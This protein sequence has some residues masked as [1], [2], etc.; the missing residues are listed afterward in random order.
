MAAAN[1]C[2][3][4]CLIF[5][6]NSSDSAKIL[7]VF[8]TAAP[9][10]YILGNALLR[11]L[12]EAGH[13]V[14]MIK[15]IKKIDPFM[16]EYKSPMLSVVMGSLFSTAYTEK[17]L[18][19]TE[20]QKLV[21]S[22][23]KF[24]VVIAGQFANDAV[25]AFAAHFDAHLIIFSSVY[26]NSMI[27]HLVGNP[28]LPS[29]APEIMSNF[30][31]R[32]SF[33]QRLYNTIIKFIFYMTHVIW[34]YPIQNGLIKKYFPQPVEIDEVLYNVSLILL[35]SHPSISSPQPYV[36]CM[37]DIGGFHIKP[38][39]KLPA[40]LQS[41]LDNATEGVIYFSMG[42][43]IKSKDLPLEK[44]NAILKAFSNLKEKVL[45]K[46]EDDVLPDQSPNVRL[47]KWL[48]QQDILGR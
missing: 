32:M 37:I 30:P 20:V 22:N 17:T 14:T 38:P 7:G 16:A 28:S 42:S 18:N 36:P 21:R 34:V 47:G 4:F 10:H 9:S 15:A 43:N 46:W 11:G 45:W 3:I 41:F 27:N 6:T 8:P 29:F 25:K 1:S 5:L 24:D 13:N 31:P 19:H 2:L 26:A 39:K 48:P 35:N 12:A 33:F 40:D 23:E 44:R